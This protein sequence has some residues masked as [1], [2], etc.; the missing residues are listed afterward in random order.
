MLLSQAVEHRL[1]ED[2]R[3]HLRQQHDENAANLRGRFAAFQSMEQC[4]RQA[5][6]RPDDTIEPALAIDVQQVA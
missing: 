1:R 6:G 4:E 3:T 5:D 2:E